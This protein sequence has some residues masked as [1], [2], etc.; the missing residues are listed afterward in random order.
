MNLSVTGVSVSQA[1]TLLSTRI[2]KNHPRSKLVFKYLKCTCDGCDNVTTSS[3][4]GGVSP[5]MFDPLSQN[6]F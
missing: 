5:M 6:T 3:K 4:D 2:L 1:V